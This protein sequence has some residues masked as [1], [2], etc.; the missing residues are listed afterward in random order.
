MTRQDLDAEMAAMWDRIQ[1][2]KAD[3]PMRPEPFQV[4]TTTT[5]LVQTATP[6]P[7]EIIEVNNYAGDPVPNPDSQGL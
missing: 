2:R 5:S 1:A 6:Q 3:V 4:T 7:A